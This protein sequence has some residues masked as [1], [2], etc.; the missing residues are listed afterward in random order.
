MEGSGFCRFFFVMVKRGQWL[1]VK[2]ATLRLVWKF[3]HFYSNFSNDYRQLS[4]NKYLTKNHI[5]IPNNY[6]NLNKN[7][8]PYQLPKSLISTWQKKNKAISNLQH[9]IYE[10]TINLLILLHTCYT[11]TNR[12]FHQKIILISSDKN[13]FIRCCLLLL[14]WEC[15]L[16]WISQLHQGFHRHS[17]SL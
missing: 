10:S 9:A 7:S 15:S 3:S 17:I 14:T 1:F 5:I 8:H 11:P 6:E 16:A 12:I 4:L 13:E 2:I